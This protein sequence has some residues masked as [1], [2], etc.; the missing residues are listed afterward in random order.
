MPASELKKYLERRT[1]ELALRD[2][3]EQTPEIDNS[4]PS[5]NEPIFGSALPSIP[6]PHPGDKPP[7]SPPS[8]PTEP[9]GGNFSLEL[10]TFLPGASVN[11]MDGD[12]KRVF[13]GKVEGMQRLN[14]PR[15]LYRVHGEHS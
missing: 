1:S 13:I 6:P 10:H 9:E 2:G 5:V 15:G 8:P 11:V 4:F 14:L 7:A 12:Q 3:I